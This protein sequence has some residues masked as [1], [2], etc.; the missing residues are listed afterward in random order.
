MT[1]FEKDKDINDLTLKVL[2]QVA[3]GTSNDK[4]LKVIQNA[5]LREGPSKRYSVVGSVPKGS[6]IEHFKTG[7]TD[8][9]GGQ[10]YK[11]LPSKTLIGF[12]PSTSCT[13]I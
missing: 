1:D 13:I 2:D 8:E 6:V 11:V 10:W 12:L 9:E 5:N 3:G 4:K 7:Y